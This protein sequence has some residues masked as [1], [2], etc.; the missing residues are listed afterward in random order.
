MTT[1]SHKLIGRDEDGYIWFW[2]H[3]NDVWRGDS[4]HLLMGADGWP[5]GLRWECSLAHFQH[6]R[7]TAY[8]WVLEPEGSATP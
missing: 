3:A 7:H 4:P 2:S 6:Y 1:Q 5:M 8:D